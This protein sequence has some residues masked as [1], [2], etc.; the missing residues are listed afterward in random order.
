MATKI[1]FD[2]HCR[3]NDGSGV[4]LS[5]LRRDRNHPSIILWS[6]GN[7]LIERGHPEGARIAGMLADFVRQ[8]E[9]TRPVTAGICDLWGAGPW[10]QL[11]ELFSH[12]DVCGYNYEVVAGVEDHKRLPER[13]V[14]GT[15]SFPKRGLHL[16]AEGWA[17]RVWWATLSGPHSTI[18]ESGHRS[19]QRRA[20]HRPY[21]RWPW[22]QANCGDID[23]CGWKRPNRSIAISSGALPQNRSLPYTATAGGF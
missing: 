13:I 23:L 5:M 2:Y 21:A 7:E 8:H 17:E 16:L 6:I 20:A 14:V 22:H 12:L 11:D 4:M 15:N 19:H 10:S 3:F 1:P 18:S 9:P